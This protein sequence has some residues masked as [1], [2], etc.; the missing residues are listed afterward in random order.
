MN[1]YLKL[2]AAAAFSLT[3]A[4]CAHQSRYCCD[5]YAAAPVSATSYEA[6]Y[7]HP[8]ASSACSSRTCT[9]TPCTDQLCAN[10]SLVIN[11][12]GYGAPK[13]TFENL[14]QRRLMAMR[15]SELD[16]Y[17]KLA[18]QVSGLHLFGS[19]SVN[20]YIAG[21]D[22]LRSQVNSFIQG[23]AI[24]H[25]EFEDDGM[26]ITTMSLKISKYRLQRILDREMYRYHTGGNLPPGGA[27]SNH[28][29]F[30][31]RY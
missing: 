7:M 22:R 13:S 4:G 21:R 24:V 8:S 17:R 31:P 10:D 25:Q 5:S 3:L 12:T 27:Y 6:P 20:D 18:E 2:T 29:F 28:G 30:A 23:A 14:A 15:A 19:T 26:A 9:P 11:V 1:S 16:A